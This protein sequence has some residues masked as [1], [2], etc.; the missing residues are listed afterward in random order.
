MLTC[1]VWG[2]VIALSVNMSVYGPKMSTSHEKYLYP[3]RETYKEEKYTSQTS[4]GE[5]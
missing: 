5:L 3:F 2:G 4:H 1:A